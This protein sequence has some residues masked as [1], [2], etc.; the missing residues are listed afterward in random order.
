[1]TDNEQPLISHLIE[2]RSRI[3]KAVLSVALLTLVMFP[4]AGK[5]YTLIAQPV[6]NN[7]NDGNGMIATGVLSPFLTPFKL[8]MILAVIAAMPIILYQMWAF[9]APGL[10]QN[11]KRIATPV[12]IS[13]IVLFY[14]GCLFAYVV[15]FPILF[16][17]LPSILPEGVT[18]MPDITSYLD[19]VVRL[20]FAFGLAFE[21]PVVVIILIVLKV[22]TASQLSQSR[23]YVIIGVFVVS[24]ILTPPDP[25]SMILLAI[26]M[27]LLFEFGLL[28]GRALKSS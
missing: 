16:N 20:F 28:M 25:S 6:I 26:P 17:F 2:L 27:W 5:I 4:F 18:Y 3:L 8:V 23:P 13:S 11:E 12:L 9:V 1:M 10:Y 7:L 15:V 24:M 19:I 21:I 22:T 14:L